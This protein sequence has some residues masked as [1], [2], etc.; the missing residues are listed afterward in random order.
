LYI[1]TKF[2]V[3]WDGTLTA[4]EGNFKGTISGS[5]IEG[6]TISGSTIKAGTLQSTS[7]NGLINLNG[8]FKVN[9]DSRLCIGYV[10]MNS[11][12]TSDAYTDGLGL[13]VSSGEISSYVKA[14]TGNAGLSYSNKS[15]KGWITMGSKL[16]IY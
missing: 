14:T 7:T 12:D 4:S 2:S 15:S 3:K 5:T 6:S 13:L 9:D 16:Q 11:G 10:Q 1:G 8:Y